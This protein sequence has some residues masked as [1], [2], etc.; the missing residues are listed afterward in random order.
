MNKYRVC[1]VYFPEPRVEIYSFRLDLIYRNW[2]IRKITLPLTVPHPRGNS[3]FCL[4]KNPMLRSL[5]QGARPD[6]VQVK[7][8]SGLFPGELVS[9][10]RPPIGNVFE[11]GGLTMLNDGQKT[12]KEMAG[13]GIE[14]TKTHSKKME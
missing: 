10:V 13:L 4:P 6:H 7:S 14:R 12:M 11:L 5:L 9:F 1:W 8:L 2:S 3:E